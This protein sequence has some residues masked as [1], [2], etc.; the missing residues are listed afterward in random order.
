MLSNRIKLMKV[1]DK[2]CQ[3]NLK[4]NDTINAIGNKDNAII[5]F[6]NG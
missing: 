5:W 3:S 1:Q 6:E 2:S 4:E